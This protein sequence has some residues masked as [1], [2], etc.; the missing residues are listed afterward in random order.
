[1]WLSLGCPKP[2]AVRIYVGRIETKER[3]WSAPR[4]IA[5][6]NA[7]ELFDSAKLTCRRIYRVYGSCGHRNRVSFFE[8]H[9]GVSYGTAFAVHCSDITGTNEY[10]EVQMY[11]SNEYQC[12]KCILGQ[13][14][15]GI[16]ENSRTGK[17]IDAESG[18]EID[19]FGG[20]KLRGKYVS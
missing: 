4:H 8:S 12:D 9:Y 16:F 20:H 18:D 7:N 11:G 6:A 2:E 19:Y 1:M 3:I 17:I 15:D 5:D 14:S 13:D 10:V